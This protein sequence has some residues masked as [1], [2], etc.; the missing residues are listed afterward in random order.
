MNDL[1]APEPVIKWSEEWWAKAKPEVR[2]HRCTAHRK[3]GDRCK[4]AAIQGG[5]VCTHHGGSAPAVK[6]KA[7]QRLEDAA[8]R[9]AHEL[10]KMAVDENVS[11]A[12]KLAAIRDAL[13]RAGLSA[14]TAVS[15][16]IAPKPWEQIFED[17]SRDSR[18]ESRRQRG[19]PDNDGLDA[20]EGINTT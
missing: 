16:A 20:I 18:A 7:R 13:D 14:R 15:V 9:M 17:I 6:A 19:M 5:R 12:V 4:R 1:S 3:N 11:D 10:L 2:A 8:D